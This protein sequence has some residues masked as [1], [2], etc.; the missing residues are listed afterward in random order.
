MNSL[1]KRNET[2]IFFVALIFSILVTILRRPDIIMNAQ[3]WAE[4]GFIWFTQMR[5]DGL[6][7]LLLSQDGYY[8]TVSRLAALL[9]VFAPLKFAPLVMNIVAIF[10]K[11]L[12]VALLFTK[13][14]EHICPNLIIRLFAASFILLVPGTQE[15]HGN[16]TSAHW[17][18]SPIALL[19]I[20]ADS[21]KSY[22]VK[23]CDLVIVCVAGLSGPFSII[24]APL[25]LLWVYIQ[26][27]SLSLH[28]KLLVAAI[29]FMAS[30]QA[31]SVYLSSDVRSQTELGASISIFAK[32]MAS[33]AFGPVFF[34]TKTSDNIWE[35]AALIFI[36]FSFGMAL[37]IYGFY[38]A[39]PSIR[40]VLIY[41]VLVLAAALY[42]PMISFD[43]NAQQWHLLKEGGERY[44][45]IPQI[46]L[47]ICF[48]IFVARNW[49]DGRFIN[50]LIVIGFICILVSLRNDFEINALQNCQWKQQ[51]TLFENGEL[52]GN[53]IGINPSCNPNLWYVDLTEK[54]DFIET[55]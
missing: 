13:R 6:S 28:N 5:R 53:R 38:R 49:G 36:V 39:K 43:P 32:F 50:G 48:L 33:R 40:I 20:L 51:I 8:Q 37:L 24:I 9:A 54:I 3:F 15:V 22:F 25:A 27:H 44:F 55:N 19:L 30:I 45:V 2:S 12:L 46:C 16:V 26:R 47:F 21:P 18:L 10:I 42:S 1:T 11:S 41:G 35:N 29:F 52:D 7:S 34:G 4:D 23:L 17:F 14:L 31:S